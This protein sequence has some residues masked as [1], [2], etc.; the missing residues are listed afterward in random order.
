MSIY[1]YHHSG[2]YHDDGYLNYA[3][4]TGFLWALISQMGFGVME[5][6]YFHEDWSYLTGVGV[7]MFTWGMELVYGTIFIMW[8][9]AF[10][11]DINWGRYYFR[12][13]Q[14]LVPASW[15]VA[16]AANV[17]ILLGA[18]GSEDDPII[19]LYPFGYDLIFVGLGAI[20]YFGLGQGNVNYYRW[21]E[22]TWWNNE[23][24]DWFIIF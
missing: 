24:D 16:I 8:S 23:D 9:L 22:Q 15:A 20:I 4:W 12:T 3:A 13:V 17:C 10:I 7:E 18:I 2:N 21:D 19:L 11:N 6:F 1:S 14:W 5:W